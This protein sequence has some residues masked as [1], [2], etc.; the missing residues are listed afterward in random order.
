MPSLDDLPPFDEL[1]VGGPLAFFLALIACALLA[2][3]PRRDALAAALGCGLGYLV[4]H[5]YLIGWLL[6]GS[7]PSLAAVRAEQWLSWLVAIAAGVSAYLASAGGFF[8][9]ALP[10]VLGAAL[11]VSIQLPIL[12]MSEGLGDRALLLSAT[13]AMWLGAWCSSSWATSAGTARR[14]VALFGLVGLATSLAVG[15]SGTRKLAQLA[16]AGTAAVLGVLVFALAAER[17]DAEPRSGLARG[18][19]GPT[20][21]WAA[22]LLLAAY[23]FAELSWDVGLL[24]FGPLLLAGPVSHL[25]R[26]RSFGADVAYVLAAGLPALV[27]LTLAALRFEPEPEYD[28]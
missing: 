2:R 15:F 14:H 3:G 6:P 20:A 7:V 24:C 9:V 11:V 1:L 5:V 8:R 12:K 13:G 27:G 22:A 16:G 10:V 28:W 17:R 19:L 18:A 26:G 4:L 25:V 23:H 21:V